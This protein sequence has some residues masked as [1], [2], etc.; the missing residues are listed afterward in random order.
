MTLTPPPIQPYFDPLQIP[1]III[2]TIAY[3][4][5]ST[6]SLFCACILGR[7][8]IQKNYRMH[9]PFLVIV[10]FVFTVSTVFMVMF[11]MAFNI[12]ANYAFAQA[13]P[14]VGLGVYPVPPL[15]LNRINT[16]SRIGNVGYLLGNWLMDGLVAWRCITICKRC[17]NR[18]I[19]IA[20]YCT[21]SLLCLASIGLGALILG[22]FG[23]FLMWGTLLAVSLLLNIVATV[24]IV[25]HLLFYR[26]RIVQV[27][28]KNYGSHY[29]RAILILVE[30][31]SLYSAFVI[32]YISAVYAGG[33]SLSTAFAQV[34]PHVQAIA[35]LLIILRVMYG[36]EHTEAT[37]EHATA[38]SALVFRAPFPA[39]TTSSDAGIHT[40]A[41][42]SPSEVGSVS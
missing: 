42:R 19:R 22:P 15:N 32:M 31:A 9:L 11:G 41:P 1:G 39:Q 23:G 5:T 16:L 24:V 26:R 33:A 12:E 20:I 35:S 3:T 28:G 30:S 36:R 37:G 25:S 21:L 38:G 2:G 10:C 27:F 7:Q 4:I 34:L 6:L 8:I 17:E 14:S 13:Y 40:P 29:T 18:I